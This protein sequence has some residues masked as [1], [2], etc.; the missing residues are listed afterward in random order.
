[1]QFTF[2]F[3]VLPKVHYVVIL[4]IFKV[5]PKERQKGC[6][7]LLREYYNTLCKH[8]IA[9]HKNLNNMEKQNRKTLLVRSWKGIRTRQ[10]DSVFIDVFFMNGDSGIYIIKYSLNKF[11]LSV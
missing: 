10:F 9:D 3:K 4:F 8:V 11:W 7:H 5:L 1:M 2:I 6:K